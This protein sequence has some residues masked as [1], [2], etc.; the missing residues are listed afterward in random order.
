[1]VNEAILNSM[2]NEVHLNEPAT[3]FRI[4]PRKDGFY[5]PLLHKHL[6]GRKFNELIM[7]ISL[8]RLLEK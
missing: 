2:D 8:N 4:G 7:L 3:D 6:S 1:M 5:F